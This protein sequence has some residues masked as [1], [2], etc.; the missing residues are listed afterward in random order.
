MAKR[1]RTSK[2]KT[3]QQDDIH[4]RMTPAELAVKCAASND[5]GEPVTE[6]QIGELAQRGGLLDSAGTLDL[7]EYTAFLI[8]ELYGSAKRTD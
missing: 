2:R 3:E 1:Q 7:A 4:Q 8:Q 6:Q 5:A